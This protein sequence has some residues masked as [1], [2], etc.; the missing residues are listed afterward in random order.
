M[1]NAMRPIVP[2]PPP[3]RFPRY[4]IM[5]NENVERFILELHVATTPILYYMRW[6]R[7]PR[8]KNLQREQL[9]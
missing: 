9:S 3:T 7:V 6:N 2:H 8:K 4:C 1:T 5:Q